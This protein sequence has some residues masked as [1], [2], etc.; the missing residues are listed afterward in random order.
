MLREV[1]TDFEDRGMYTVGFSSIMEYSLL[2]Y[3][4]TEANSKI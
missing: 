2:Q 1:G 3:K 4:Y